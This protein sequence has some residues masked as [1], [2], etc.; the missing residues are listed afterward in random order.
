MKKYYQLEFTLDPKI[1]GRYEMPHTVEITSK[2]FISYTR[3]F[4]TNIEMYVE[5]KAMFYCNMP[6]GITGKLLKRKTFID[7]MDFTPFVFSLV[8]VIS[9]KIKMIFDNL[10][11]REDECVLKKITIKNEDKNYYLMFVPLI[12]D[13]EF[14]YS[15]CVFM[16]F[17][18][19][20]QI[21]LFNSREEYYNSLGDYTLKKIT[22][23]LKYA[24]YKILN[25]Q[26]SDVF[27]SEDIIKAFE[28]ENIQG[29]EIITRGEFLRELYFDNE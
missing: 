29:Y 4:A 14:I 6:E 23:P 20:Q 21:V 28:Q 27:F 5:N 10:G 13:T 25:P 9:E 24:S 7:Y 1:R 18:D 17:F 3:T 26:N 12:R 16:P 15:K 11:V 2:E 22:L 19:R 8:A